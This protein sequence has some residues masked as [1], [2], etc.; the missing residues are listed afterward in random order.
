MIGINSMRHKKRDK[1]TEEQYEKKLDA[2]KQAGEELQ[3][4]WNELVMAFAT[5]LKLDK[6]VY[7]LAPKLEKLDNKIK[8]IL[9]R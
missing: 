1:V 6:L 9:S 8:R 3:R 2:Q 7:W 4:A 5:K